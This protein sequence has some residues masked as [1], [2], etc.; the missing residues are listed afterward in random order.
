MS[1]GA[2]LDEPLIYTSKGNLLIS[3]LTQRD[4]WT[5]NEDEIILASESWLAGECV[6]RQVHIKKLQGASALVE[7]GV[8]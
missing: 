5:V 3:S 7:A 6:R 2:L 8:F 1:N 4:V